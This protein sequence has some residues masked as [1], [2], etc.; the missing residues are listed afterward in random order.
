MCK[1]INLAQGEWWERYILRMRTRE[2]NVSAYVI[3]QY[4]KLLNM[5]GQ[6]ACNTIMLIKVSKALTNS[7]HT[8]TFVRLHKTHKMIF[9]NNANRLIFST[10]SFEFALT[11]SSQRDSFT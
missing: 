3:I 1:S 11:D 7:L 5:R 10:G 8:L 2:P 9:I 4:D 6:K